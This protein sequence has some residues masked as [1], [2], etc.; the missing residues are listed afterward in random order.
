MPKDNGPIITETDEISVGAG[1]TAYS[2]AFLIVDQ[3][4]FALEYK[5]ACTGSPNLKIQL[6]QR[7]SSSIDWYI[8]TNM[9]DVVPSL[10]D[11]NQHGIRL[12]PIPIAWIRFKITEQT[13]TVTDSVL[14]ISLSVQK[15]YSV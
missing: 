7:S 13:S 6:Q 5:V 8:P 12:G 14:T 1:E 3:D 9:P 10:T 15:R 4:T 11:K 2:D